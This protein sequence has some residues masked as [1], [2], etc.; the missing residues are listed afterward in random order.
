MWLALCGKLRGGEGVCDCLARGL[1]I[2]A[3]FAV[4]CD[5]GGDAT[6]SKDVREYVRVSA[7]RSGVKGQRGWRVGRG[8]RMARGRF[9]RRV[10]LVSLAS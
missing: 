7:S 4:R 3:K 10:R 2:D 8:V 5:P 9:G 1:F 6:L